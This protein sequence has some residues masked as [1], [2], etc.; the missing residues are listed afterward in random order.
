MQ[1]NMG[2]AAAL[3]FVSMQPGEQPEAGGQQ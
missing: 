2:Q 3:G 1:F